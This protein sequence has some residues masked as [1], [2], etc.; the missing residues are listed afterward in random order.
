M[1]VSRAPRRYSARMRVML[2]ASAA[3]AIMGWAYAVPSAV[4]SASAPLASAPVPGRP[5]PPFSV[6]AL[7]GGGQVTL[8]QFAGHPLVI[9]FFNS[10]CGVC[11]PDLSLL[12]K[13]YGRYR[14]RGLVIVGVGVQDTA[15]S[16]R[17]MITS[18]NVTFPVGNDEKGASAARYRL[19]SIPTTVL[20]GA[21][22][23]VKSVLE[24][25]LDDRTLQKNLA[26]ILPRSASAP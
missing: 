8:A 2:I 14:S 15:D 17:Q 25:N 24:G 13:V 10:D 1:Q 5:A 23:V 7:T 9:T 21:D 12:Q 20:V 22:G 4:Y 11:R 19:T 16:L 6:P 26:L 3:A 18:L